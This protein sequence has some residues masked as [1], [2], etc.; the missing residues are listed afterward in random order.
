MVKDSQLYKL[1]PNLSWNNSMNNST[2]FAKFNRQDVLSEQLTVANVL[3]NFVSHYSYNDDG[4]HY[5]KK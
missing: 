3:N 4:E 1:G 5:K 2:A